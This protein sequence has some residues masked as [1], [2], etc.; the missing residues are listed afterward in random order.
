MI[1]AMTKSLQVQYRRPHAQLHTF[2][3]KSRR[4]KIYSRIMNASSTL[5]ETYIRVMQ[6]PRRSLVTVYTTKLGI[7]L[8]SVCSSFSIIASLLIIIVILRSSKGLKSVYHRIMFGMSI[9]CIVQSLAMAMVTLPMPPSSGYEDTATASDPTSWTI[10]DQFEGIRGGTWNT[11]HAQ[12]FF[13]VFGTLAQTTYMSV[14]CIYYLSSIVF[15]IKDAR[16]SRTVEPLMHCVAIGFSLTVAILSVE[17]DVINPTPFRSFCSTSG[18]PWWCGDTDS[19]TD[20]LYND[21]TQKA[22][23]QRRRLRKIAG[24]GFAFTSTTAFCGLVIVV[25][26][27]YAREYKMALYRN[28]AERPGITDGEGS[29]NI[30]ISS[31]TVTERTQIRIY[32]DD[33]K[34]TKTVM[35]QSALYVGATFIAY[36]TLGIRAAADKSEDIDTNPLANFLTTNRIFQFVDIILRPSQGCTNLVIFLYL[37]VYNIRRK[38]N[39]HIE[40]SEVLKLIFFGSKEEEVSEYL[41]SGLELVKLDGALVKMRYEFENRNKEA[42]IDE[43]IHMEITEDKKEEMLDDDH[44]DHGRR[45]I[46]RAGDTGFSPASGVFGGSI[47]L[48]SFGGSTKSKL[49]AFFGS[50]GTNDLVSFETNRS[51]NIE[52]RDLEHDSK[53]SFDSASII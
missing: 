17:I 48:P 25:L 12:G 4:T 34:Y 19:D 18:Y 41:V 49:S 32:Q 46:R 14:L 1:M 16:F 28:D 20:C 29:G 47:I 7:V 39:A 37:M 52:D 27:V 21:N 11:C 38:K 36:C 13:H 6:D 5:E 9:A 51:S 44:V 42:I 45:D 26:T 15:R 33:L 3:L 35:K 50:I 23:S 31:I 2:H 10:Y 30:N 24:F 22:M 53:V 40:L 43:D 8:T